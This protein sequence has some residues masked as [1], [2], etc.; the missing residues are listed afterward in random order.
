MSA[1][2]ASSGANVGAFTTLTLGRSANAIDLLV[3]TAPPVHATAD[4]KARCFDYLSDLLLEHSTLFSSAELIAAYGHIPSS[5]YNAALESATICTT[6]QTAFFLVNNLIGLG[7]R[8]HDG[9]PILAAIATDPLTRP[10]G[11]CYFAFRSTVH[12]AFHPALLNSRL[13]LPS[14][15]FEFLLALPQTTIARDPADP[16]RNLLSAFNSPA[17]PA[18]RVPT[19]PM[20]M[21]AA[22]LKAMTAV[23]LAAL[24]TDDSTD[25]LADYAAD[26]Y[27]LFTS[28][29]LQKLLLRNVPA[30]AP[31]NS[32]VLSPRMT[33]VLAAN[34][35]S[36]GFSYH[37][38]LDF[39]DSQSIFDSTFPV[40]TPLIVTKSSV[41]AV[42]IRKAINLV[43]DQ[44]KFRA[45]VP[46]FRS[47]YVGTADRNDSLS[48]HATVQTL[49][50]FNM[51]TRNP[52]TGHWTNISPD[53]VFAE[54]SALTP[55]LPT[56]VSLWG[57]NLVTQYHDALSPDLQEL[58][59]ADT[60][61]SVPD[62][63]TL[64]TRA[65]Q[66]SALRSLRVIAVRHYT[67]M[68]AQEKLVAKTIARKMKHGAMA[69]PFSAEKP[70]LPAP[71]PPAWTRSFVSPAEQT[72]QRYQ[73][74]PS[75]SSTAPTFP[76]DP[77]TN[78]QSTYPVGF[79]GCMFCGSPDHVFRACPQH[80]APGANSVFYKHL[81]AH[82][83]HLRKRP[84][85]ASEMVAA[86]AATQSFPV[87]PSAPPSIP[88]PLP[89]LGPA[90]QPP[91]SPSAPA[92][93]P[94]PSI[95]RSPAADARSPAA[96]VSKRPRFL[97]TTV[98]SFQVNLPSVLPPMP[99]AINNGLPHVTVCLGSNSDQDPTLTGLM[100]TCGALNTGYLPFHLW[101]MSQRPDIVAEFNSFDDSNPFE[102]VKLGG[103]IRDPDNF[104][105]SDHGNLTAV[106]RYFTP[107]V[108]QE[109]NAIRLSFALGNDVTVNTIFGLPMLSD[110]DSVISLRSNSLHSRS[111]DLDFPITRAAA[112]F[113]LPPGCAFDPSTAARS[114]ASTSGLDPSATAKLAPAS[115]SPPR[116]IA[117][118]DTSLGYL[119]RTVH[120]SH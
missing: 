36:G 71:S 54:Y 75:A 98:R 65:A 77:A 12:P 110:L 13:P 107:Y 35:S 93:A 76:V 68:K 72:M 55:L 106:I 78:Y 2:T 119:Q 118:D 112:T 19:P 99:V 10:P 24:G 49:K 89:D 120:S 97:V 26:C 25:T 85:Q 94:P 18:V 37:G 80:E 73:S 114:H 113:G 1:T 58:I 32:D 59:N 83:P 20:L 90:G 16:A 9:T 22:D 40:P 88:V 92:P 95:L 79:A 69:A 17:A 117:S 50:K 11:I 34:T 60:T 104:D 27:P 45:F 42:S 103:A 115:V 29:Q 62:L 108:D 38:S 21:E 86:P 5:S 3:P 31:T 82:K 51:S 47:D 96:D 44:C 41:D 4:L 64:T 43:I 70:A 116:A 63:S 61:Y 53:E 28:L 91:A 52:S 46:I 39:L 102:P 111:L 81:F 48:L 101:L 30:P 100:D 87:L 23:A 33:A 84:P 57:L 67:L 14:S 8:A 105:S 66:L 15:T 56:Q 74:G 109:G 7:F 6:I